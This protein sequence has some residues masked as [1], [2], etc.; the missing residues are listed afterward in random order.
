MRRARQSLQ[1]F[2]FEKVVLARRAC[3]MTDDE[4]MAIIDE[5]KRQLAILNDGDTQ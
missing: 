1:G 4:L 5:T 2:D 3:D